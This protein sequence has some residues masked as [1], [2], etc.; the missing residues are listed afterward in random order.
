MKSVFQDALDDFFS[1]IAHLK[2]AQRALDEPRI[3]GTPPAGM[4]A[5]VYI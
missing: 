3:G 2:P 1:V 4:R 5:E